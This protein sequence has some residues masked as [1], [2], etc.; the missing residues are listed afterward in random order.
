MTRQATEENKAWIVTVDMGYGH[1]RAV[2]GLDFL[3]NEEI[4]TI[5]NSKYTSAKEKKQ[6]KRMLH[7]YEFLSRSKS[8]PLIGK[9]LFKMLDVM[10]E[11][12]TFY[13]K[14][15]LS[16]KTFQVDLLYR[17]VKKGICN[18]VMQ[19]MNEDKSL[20]IVTS[21]YAPA[22]AADLQ[23]YPN[24]YLIICDTD[25]NRVWVAAE[26]EKS[27]IN[28]FVPCY[29]AA[30][31]LKS[32]G[33]S[34][35]KIFLTGFPFSKILTGE[36]DLSILKHDLAQRLFYLDPFNRFWDLHRVEVEHY[37]GKENCE[38][39]NRRVV[40][41]LFA[42]GGA[43]AQKEIGEKIA[44]S[45][46]KKLRAGKAK[47]ILSAG[48]RKDVKLYFDE[49][50]QNLGNIPNIEIIYSD[51]KAE[52]LKRF[53]DAIKNTDVLWTKPS[54]LVFYCGLGLPIIMTPPIGAQERANRDWLR[55][56]QSGFKQYKPKY[57][58]E[59]LFDLLNQGR[60]AEAAWAGFLK[61]RKMGTFKMLEV[62]ATGK[63]TESVFPLER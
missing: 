33:V 26:P 46:V 57:A 52:Y 47:L 43:G 61:A 51:S 9:Y 39:L 62:L 54:E 6:W 30:Q 35:D 14:R 28:Y 37:L 38:F 12:P 20:P 3:A 8:I 60:L 36:Q 41:I 59:W 22:I 42:V 29:K 40:T 58:N 32:Y 19:K 27:N 34:K 63:V 49:V 21:F 7:S 53:D 31:R 55:E 1:Q 44:R 50:C 2:H 45:L 56:I 15:N 13:P 24:I 11:I 4:I 17:Y 10:L 48:T 18:G 16:Q 23:N 5:G 25:L